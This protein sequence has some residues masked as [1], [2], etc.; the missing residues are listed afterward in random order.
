MASGDMALGMRI[1]PVSPAFPCSSAEL[2]AMRHA[3]LARPECVA[4]GGIFVGAAT[5]SGG[6]EAAWRASADCWARLPDQLRAAWCS[7]D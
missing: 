7:S 5:S 4:A 1:W 2:P 3:A 6:D